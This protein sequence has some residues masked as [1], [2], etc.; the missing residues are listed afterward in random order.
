MLSARVYEVF[1]PV[2]LMIGPYQQSLNRFG[3]EIPDPK[4]LGLGT[5]TLSASAVDTKQMTRI[6]RIGLLLAVCQKAANLYCA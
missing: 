3:I 2:A 5:N 4:G 6:G 1:L